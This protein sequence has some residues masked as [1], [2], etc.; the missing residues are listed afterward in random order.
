[1][2]W[3]GVSQASPV[4]PYMLTHRQSDGTLVAY[5]LHGDERR[6]FMTTID[7]LLLCQDGEGNL[8]YAD[9]KDGCPVA[10]R[11]LRHDSRTKAESLFA[12]RRPRF[13]AKD[14]PL[15]RERRLETPRR[16][17]PQELDGFRGL[18][19]LVEYNDRS[20][21][22]PDPRGCYDHLLNDA[23]YKGFTDH[24][25]QQQSYTGSVRDYFA[26][27]SLGAFSPHFDV[28]GPVRID[29][30]STY[31]NQT[32]RLAEILYTTLQKADSIV[33][34][35]QYDSN[36]DGV[37]DMV[38]FV[39]AGYGSNYTGG[40]EIYP[41]ASNMYGMTLDGVQISRYACGCELWG[42]SSLSAPDGIGVF[43]H[44]FSHLL[45][46]H[47]LYDADYANS[48]G[49][50]DTPGKW[51]V[52]ANGLY[53]DMGRTPV[54]YSLGERMTAGFCTPTPLDST[55]D[56]ALDAIHLRG[57]G[58]MAPSAV[59]GEYFLFENR[60]PSTWDA[61]LP[62]HGML[63]YRVDK[64]DPLAW[65]NNQV[66]VNP[67]ALHYELLRAD[68]QTVEL[69]YRTQVV[70][71]E[72][73]PFPGS[74]GATELSNT[75]TPSL[76]SAYGIDNH[77]ALSSITEDA[78]GRITF[79]ADVGKRYIARTDWSKLASTAEGTSVYEDSLATWRMSSG[80]R[81]YQ[82][83]MQF[84]KKG[85]LTIEQMASA[86]ALMRFDLC[87]NTGGEAVFQLKYSL[88]DGYTWLVATTHSGSD[89]YE[90]QPL[91]TQPCTYNL[92]ELHTAAGKAPMLRI[93]EFGGPTKE[94]VSLENLEFEF[95]SPVT[96]IHSPQAV[97]LRSTP[98]AYGID[99]RPAT[100]TQ[101]GIIIK[102][103]KKYLNR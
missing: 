2:L 101:K 43:C 16:V 20:F 15:F 33:D 32:E 100:S 26:D 45:G 81:L 69:D 55:G 61:S 22:E 51:S 23:G 24:A 53:V 88:D 38:Y 48:G 90:V 7:G 85:S 59:R 96:C 64:S 27:N 8:C 74:S 35:S 25:G 31:V 76:C 78:D 73:D 56:Y 83:T 41:H 42:N 11:T 6:N 70:D 49:Y 54:G 80:A 82:D 13:T 52:M 92:R 14:L 29:Y 19:I 95:D 87:N 99:G 66:N 46:L 34:F 94:Y 47:D 75:T 72:N 30:S 21:A 9:L 10:T 97:Q 37:A 58:Y 77:L 68:R 18:V 44:E 62:G 89:R 63:V 39:F 103:G 91:H 50:A 12:A 79:H 98:K 3:S 65:E 93:V 57:S 67:E 1:M 36:H 5:C 28:V 17:T 84:V 4:Y 102:G 60:Q 86:P 40:R 71:G